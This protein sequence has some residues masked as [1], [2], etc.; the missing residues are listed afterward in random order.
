MFM[1]SIG[2][3]WDGNEVWLVVF[4]GAMFAAFPRAYAAAFSGFYTGFMLLL[5]C[6]I[7]RGVSM[8]FRSKQD[9]PWWRAAWDTAFS[10]A[11]ALATFLFGVVVGNCVQ[12]LPLG[13]EGDLTRSLSI[14]DMLIGPEGAAAPGYPIVTGLFAVSAFAMHG[15]IYLHLKTEG[16]LQARIGRWMWITFFVFLVSYLVLTG[17]TLVALPSATANLHRYPTL[18]VVPALN[19][20]AILNIPRAI[21][22]RRPFDA[23][24]SSACVIAAATFMF[25]VALFPYM[26]IS[27]EDPANSLTVANAASTDATL[28]IMLIMAG[29]GLPFVLTYTATIYWV[30]RGKV[31]I[32]TFSY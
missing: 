14:L 26:L 24:L 30:F 19:V 28:I 13:A 12:G 17:G 21:Y 27:T 18:W 25:G 7:F 8:E 22:Q 29:I 10:V 2:P 5:C 9:W 1:N 11:S 20:L 15:A 32:G 16:E 4:G 23:F 3:L 31:K 6:L